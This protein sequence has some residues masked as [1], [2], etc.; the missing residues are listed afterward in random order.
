MYFLSSEWWACQL[1][2]RFLMRSGYFGQ[3]EQSQLV[4][5]GDQMKVALWI[6]HLMRVARFNSHEVTQRQIDNRWNYT[7]SMSVSFRNRD[8]TFDLNN[9]WP[10]IPL[11]YCWWFQY[12]KNRC[13]NQSAAGVGNVP[14]PELF[15]IRDSGMP[16]RQHQKDWGCFVTLQ[17]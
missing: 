17:L 12:E 3:E 8:F 11:R 13:G 2:I 7:I 15:N 1:A 16:A 9:I 6:H 14:H 10:Q 4:F 5:N